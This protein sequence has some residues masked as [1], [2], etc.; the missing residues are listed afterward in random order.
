[1]TKKRYRSKLARILRKKYE[2]D[3]VESHEVAKGIINGSFFSKPWDFGFKHEQKIV[4]EAG[5]DY[6]TVIGSLYTTC[7]RIS[8]TYPNGFVWIGYKD[9]VIDSEDLVIMQKN[10]P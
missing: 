1:M 9:I 2:L 4:T 7:K 6:G 5:N 8:G 10:T 3:F